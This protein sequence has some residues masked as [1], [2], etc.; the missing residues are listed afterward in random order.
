MSDGP[1]VS[2]P[3]GLRPPRRI[4]PCRVAGER[5][6]WGLPASAV[7]WERRLPLARSMSPAATQDSPVNRRPRVSHS[8]GKPLPG[9][10]CCRDGQVWQARS[11][12][13]IFTKYSLK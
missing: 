3:E 11:K 2:L 12:C 6:E 1:V 10:M 9:R 5:H 7:F 8:V 4:T 13:V